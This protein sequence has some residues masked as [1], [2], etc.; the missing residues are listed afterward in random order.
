MRLYDRS[1][2]PAFEVRRFSVAANHVI[3]ETEAKGQYEYEQL[4]LFTDFAALEKKKEQ[5]ENERRKERSIQE[6]LISIR[7]KYGNNAVLMGT[8][9]QEGSTAMERNG[10]IG[11]HKA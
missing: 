8:S 11:G 10:Q 4:D 2:N 7:K 6:A 3:P 1:V 9:L 5:E